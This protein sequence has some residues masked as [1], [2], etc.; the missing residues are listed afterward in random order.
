LD[1]SILELKKQRNEL[2]RYQNKLQTGLEKDRELAKKLVQEGKEDR[3]K[4]VL[5]NKALKEGSLKKTHFQ[6][7]ALEKTLLDLELVQ[8]VNVVDKPN[9]HNNFK[10]YGYWA[11]GGAV[12]LLLLLS[13]KGK[14][15]E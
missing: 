1:K 13:V 10:L 12:V 2:K 4:V 9:P 15:S 8:A 11:L 5:Q 14:L 7:N 6:L 3:A